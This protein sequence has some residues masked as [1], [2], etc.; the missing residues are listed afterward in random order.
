MSTHTSTMLKTPILFLGF[1]ETLKNYLQSV[2][3]YIMV[4]V[5]FN[6]SRVKHGR[7][8][9]RGLVHEGECTSV[10]AGSSWACRCTS[11]QTLGCRVFL[12]FVL[13]FSFGKWRG[14]E[15]LLVLTNVGQLQW[16][17]ATCLWRFSSNWMETYSSI[18]PTNQFIILG[19]SM[20]QFI[21]FDVLHIL[22]LVRFWYYC[23]IPSP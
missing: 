17:Q 14:R 2:D 13:V 6:I 9:T 7:L 12:H 10:S 23:I 1:F 11:H 8:L 16:L 19:G 3:Y 4:L 15:I 20:D 22:L 5:G 21:L 18:H